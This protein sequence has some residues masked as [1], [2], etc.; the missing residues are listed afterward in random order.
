MDSNHPDPLFSIA[1]NI[2][3]NVNTHKEILCRGARAWVETNQRQP[4]LVSGLSLLW[5]NS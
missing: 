3:D 1:L 2:N 4:Q 5:G